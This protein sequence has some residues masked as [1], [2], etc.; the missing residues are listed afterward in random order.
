[1]VDPIESLAF[2]MQANPGVYALLLGS[3]VSRSAE[4]PTGWEIVMDLLG[5]LAAVTDGGDDRDLEK[6]YES[7]YQEPP[8]YSK[9]LDALANTPSERQQL[10]RPYFEPD[11][12]EREEGLKQPTQAHRAI[13]R[14]VTQGFIKVIVTTNFDRLLET[15]LEEEGIAPIVL[16]TLEDVNGA[17]PLAHID[18]CVFKIHGDYRDPGIRNT[19]SELEE[20]PPEFDLFLDRVFDEYGLI[21]C[22]WSAEWDIALRK[23]L[24][25][26][27]SRRFSTYWAATGELGDSAQRLTRHRDAQVIPIEN[28]DSFFQ[29]I[30]SSVEAIDEYSKPHPLS[31]EAAVVT[32][33]RYLSTEE[34]RIRLFDLVDAA[35][36]DAIKAT[37]GEGFELG[38]PQ[39]DSTTVTARLR[40][41]DSACT[42]LIHMA[43]VGGY[44]AEAGNFAVW[45]RAAE[46]LSAT[47]L[48][49]GVLYYD[50]WRGLSMYPATLIVY[51]LGLGALEAGKFSLIRRIFEGTAT[52]LDNNG[53]QSQGTVLR[54][55][56]QERIACGDLRGQLEGM[57][58][59]RVPI[60][61]WLHDAI[62]QPLRALIPDD[63]K[64]SYTFD[65]FEIVAALAFYRM[66]DSIYGDWF[67]P[68][69]HF[70]RRANWSRAVG[71]L[72]ES[73]RDVDNATLVRSGILGDSPD[74][75]LQLIERFKDWTSRAARQFGFFLW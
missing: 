16:S 36:E 61:D 53:A 52:L 75:C 67:P 13:A 31:S 44:W 40:R 19:E 14:L 70:G 39:I 9:L 48:P 1:M 29:T 60:N 66:K 32:L 18:C 69:S 5:K 65:K 6:W 37:T 26:A 2:S 62:H 7:K 59:S 33:K 30:Q 41:Y 43:A 38:D 8:D 45:E 35:V 46:R 57:G 68:G 72:E 12:Q 10:L 50:M 74:D 47:R 42:T 73:V 34:Y 51:A 11:A 22:G 15:A 24:S 4:I 27:K 63:D 64:Y 20:Y 49:A 56:V 54:K 17:L 58:N 23:S 21:V 28:A 25:R 3:G 55:I 71:E